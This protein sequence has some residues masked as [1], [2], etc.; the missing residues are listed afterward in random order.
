MNEKRYGV[1]VLILSVVALSIS[2]LF[3]TLPL[4]VASRLISE[5]S[6]LLL[7]D[8][9]GFSLWGWIP[10]LAIGIVSFKMTWNIKTGP[11][12]AIT[13]II[14]I[15]A[16]VVALIWILT[17]LFWLIQASLSPHYK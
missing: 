5:K 7:V 15:T 14:S 10:G 3:I 4:M 11:L 16:I 9:F 8:L 1:L 6:V 12:N 17:M 2:S 13:R